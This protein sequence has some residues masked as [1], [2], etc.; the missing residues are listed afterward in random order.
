MAR[1][2]GAYAG[3]GVWERDLRRGAAWRG[4]GELGRGLGEAGPGKFPRG[5]GEAS[6]TVS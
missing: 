1:S 4:G 3:R 6:G 2:A 5:G